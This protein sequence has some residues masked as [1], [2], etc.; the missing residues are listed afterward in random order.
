MRRRGVESGHEQDMESPRCPLHIVLVP[1]VLILPSC[2][3]LLPGS[4]CIPSAPCIPLS[5]SLSP[6]CSLLPPSSC[7][8]LHVSKPPRLS[9]A[10]ASQASRPI[11]HRRR[12]MGSKAVIV[13]GLTLHDSRAS[14]GDSWRLLAAPGDDHVRPAS[15]PGRNVLLQL[16]YC[17]SEAIPQ[18]MPHRIDYRPQA[19]GYRWASVVFPFLPRRGS[20]R[21][22]GDRPADERYCWPPVCVPL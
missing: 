9:K 13:V 3:R 12:W 7:P 1:Q 5:S 8:I 21:T 19:T 4:D 6:M 17:R 2:L 11:T 10:P 22:V 14:L 18:P 20:L 15:H 16:L